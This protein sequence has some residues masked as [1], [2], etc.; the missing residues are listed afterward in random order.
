MPR[1]RLVNRIVV[2]MLARMRTKIQA[3]KLWW[4][5]L[6]SG[7]IVGLAVQVGVVHGVVHRIHCATPHW[8]CDGTGEAANSF[9]SDKF[10]KFILSRGRKSIQVEAGSDDTSI[11][12]VSEI[13]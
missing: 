11:E 7:S 5:I 3:R 8:P 12:T 10:E 13:R 1:P 2:I 4:C 6:A 9:K